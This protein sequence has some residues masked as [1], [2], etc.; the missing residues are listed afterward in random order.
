MSEE[1][2]NPWKF[3]VKTKTGDSY[4]SNKI[5]GE[6]NPGGE[7]SIKVELS[8]NATNGGGV[9]STLLIANMDLASVQENNLDQ[10]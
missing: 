9:Y 2:K 4:F 7:G 3:V 8:R 1:K 10:E 6:A 5:I